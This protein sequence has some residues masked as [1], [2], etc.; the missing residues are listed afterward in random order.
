[1]LLLLLAEAAVDQT[2]AQAYDRVG[3]IEAQ[4]ALADGT[5]LYSCFSRLRSCTKSLIYVDACYSQGFEGSIWI[6]SSLIN[7]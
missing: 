6:V 4:R 2:Q 3:V 5:T 1:M 7:E